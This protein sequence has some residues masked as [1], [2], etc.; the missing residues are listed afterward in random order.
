MTTEPALL[1]CLASLP[2]PRETTRQ[3][4]IVR[5]EPSWSA[6]TPPLLRPA[7]YRLRPRKRRSFIEMGLLWPTDKNTV[8]VRAFALPP[9]TLSTITWHTCE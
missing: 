9:A 2:V 4:A 8:R 7:R 3:A 5:Q 6:R 1:V